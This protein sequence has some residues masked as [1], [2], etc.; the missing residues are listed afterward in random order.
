MPARIRLTLKFM[1]S[2][3]GKQ[4]IA[5]HVRLPDIWRSKRNQT[6]KFIQVKKWETFFTEQAFSECGRE[7]STSRHFPKES[8]LNMS[9]D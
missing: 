6:I 9:L 4:I 1:T 8:K 2:Q 5:I 7:T 3:P